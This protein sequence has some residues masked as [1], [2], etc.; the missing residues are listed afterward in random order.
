MKSNK[1]T[2]KKEVEELKIDSFEIV[3]ATEGKG[4]VVYF[5]CKIN[6]LTVY[7]MKVV[8]LKDKTGDFLAF[9]SK[10]GADGE[11]YNIVWARFSEADSEKILRAVQEELDK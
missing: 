7:G 10:K 4:G 1:A 8:P 2:A 11:F 6:G 3:R 9:P 5:D